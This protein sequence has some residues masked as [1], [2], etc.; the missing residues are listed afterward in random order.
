MYVQDKAINLVLGNIPW[1]V[2][3]DVSTSWYYSNCWATPHPTPYEAHIANTRL[4]ACMP[5]EAE[6]RHEDDGDDEYAQQQ[7]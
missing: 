2:G 4:A 1:G 3:W 5:D 7:S 6:E